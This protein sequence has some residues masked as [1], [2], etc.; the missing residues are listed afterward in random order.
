MACYTVSM[1]VK[2]AGFGIVEMIIVVVILGLLFGIVW[3]VTA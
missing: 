3:Y 1:S 2:Q